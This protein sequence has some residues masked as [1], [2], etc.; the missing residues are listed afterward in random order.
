MSGA[1]MAKIIGQVGM[2]YPPMNHRVGRWGCRVRVLD[3]RE[4]FGRLDY[5]IEATDGV[6]R[7]WVGAGRVELEDN[8]QE[9][10]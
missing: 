9:E 3:V 1:E 6:G 5:E 4:S 2:Y 8:G 7:V 10:N